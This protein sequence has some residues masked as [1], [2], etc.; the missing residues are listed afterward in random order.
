MWGQQKAGQRGL[1]SDRRGIV[2]DMCLQAP[3]FF[4]MPLGGLGLEMGCRILR[5]SM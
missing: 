3:A 1:G 5:F 4:G 2:T